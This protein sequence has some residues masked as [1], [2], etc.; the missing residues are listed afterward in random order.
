MTLDAF[1]DSGELSALHTSLTAERDKTLVEAATGNR[2]LSLR[3][4]EKALVSCMSKELKEYDHY[5]HALQEAAFL[6]KYITLVQ[7]FAMKKMRGLYLDLSAVIGKAYCNNVEDLLFNLKDVYLRHEQLNGYLATQAFR[8]WA[9]GSAYNPHHKHKPLFRYHFP[10]C[11]FHQP[12]VLRNPCLWLENAARMF[13]TLVDAYTK[14]HGSKAYALTCSEFLWLGR[15]LHRNTATVQSTD[16]KERL[17]LKCQTHVGCK[18]ECVCLKYNAIWFPQFH[19][20]MQFACTQTLCSDDLFIEWHKTTNCCDDARKQALY[21]R[22]CA[23]CTSANVDLPPACVEFE[24]FFRPSVDWDLFCPFKLDIAYEQR[25]CAACPSQA[26]VQRAKQCLEF[27]CV[28]EDCLMVAEAKTAVKAG[29]YLTTEFKEANVNAAQWQKPLDQLL[30]FYHCAI[31]RMDM[32]LLQTE[33]SRKQIQSVVDCIRSNMSMYKNLL[34]DFVG[35]NNAQ[36]VNKLRKLSNLIEAVEGCLERTPMKV[37]ATSHK[38]GKTRVVEGGIKHAGPPPYGYRRYV[39]KTYAHP[40][41]YGPDCARDVEKDG[42]AACDDGSND[43][44]SVVSR[45]TSASGYRW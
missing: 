5:L 8:T 37:V 11:D 25:D 30:E 7:D 21:E 40:P 18:D 45:F 1:K 24:L 14:F 41:V 28:R 13:Y 32:Y 27:K 12:L 38:T 22:C 19:M 3:R 26:H 34:G 36:A 15:S 44:A 16:Y 6:H 39:P 20:Y 33:T 9:V 29:T 23:C 35:T 17:W 43:D 10:A 4:D 42:C 31:E 2:F